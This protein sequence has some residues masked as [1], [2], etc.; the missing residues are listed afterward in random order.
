P[1]FIDLERFKKQEKNHFKK[2]ICPNDEKLLV[3]IS[4]FRKVKRMHD[5]VSTFDL[6]R[7]EIPAKLLLIG[8]GPE[9]VNLEI[10]CRELGITDDVRML[11]KL[12]AVEEVLSIADLFLMP[13][14]SESFG[15]SALE[16]M[17]CEV[18]VISSDAGGIP[19]LNLNGVTG[20]TSKIGDVQDMAKNSLFVLQDDQLPIF[21]ANALA[22]AKEFDLINIVPY[23]E[24]V[25]EIASAIKK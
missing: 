2:A 9:R 25:Y 7:K 19:E 8:D 10:Q 16:A 6:V 13:S 18:P 24:N 5:V 12:D 1:N 23:Y 15:L 20:F 4:N 17:A 3:H 22:R 14:E 11:G 21:R